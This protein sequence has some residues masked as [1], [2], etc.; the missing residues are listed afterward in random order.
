MARRTRY[1]AVGMLDFAR[2]APIDAAYLRQVVAH[3]SAIGSS[4]LGFRATGTPEDRA[5]AEFAAGEMRRSGLADVALEPVS[6]DGWR[7][8]SARVAVTG[9]PHYEC[10]SMGGAPPTGQDGVLGPL[11]DVGT[12]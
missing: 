4:P 1:R 6:V 12:G 10:A 7:F 9:G 5:V 11:V 8:E 3:L 2:K